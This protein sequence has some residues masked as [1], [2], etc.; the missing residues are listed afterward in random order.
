ME[1]LSHLFGSSARVKLLRLFLFNPQ[2]SFT[3]ASL[4]SK[5]RLAKTTVKRELRM[6]EKI[7]MVKRRETGGTAQKETAKSK[8][9]TKNTEQKTRR[10]KRVDYSLNP[11]FI[12]A[13]A[14][15]ELLTL[16]DPINKKEITEKLKKVGRVKLII[17]SGLFIGSDQSRVDLLVVGDSLN[18]KEVERAVTALETEVGREIS[19]AVFDTNEFLYRATAKDRLLRDIFDYPHERVLEKIT[20]EVF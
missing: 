14:L 6:F 10:K 2:S 8:K 4:V 13:P 11:R 19:Y 1:T 3:E 7:D 17:I 9:G 20:F 18:K 12:Y 5:T 15:T 16:N